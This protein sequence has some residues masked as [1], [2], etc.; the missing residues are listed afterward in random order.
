MGAAK[1]I[2]QNVLP[3]AFNISE[4]V[5]QIFVNNDEVRTTYSF[6]N[7]PSLYS[8]KT[9]AEYFYQIKLYSPNGK[10]FA[11]TKIKVPPFGSTYFVPEQYFG[12]ELPEF[13]MITAEIKP[14]NIFYNSDKHLGKITSHFYAMFMDKG[15]NSVGVI[16][17]QVRIKRKARNQKS[18]VSNQVIETKGLVKIVNYQLNPTGVSLNSNISLVELGGKVIETQ[19]NKLTPYSSSKNV[20][21]NFANCQKV[22]F[23]IDKISAANAKPLIRRS[24]RQMQVWI[25]CW[26]KKW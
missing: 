5:V 25:L 1:K 20:W 21:N 7:F 23:R 10:L 24:S 22:T 13:G 6:T 19:K 26:K 17:P 4:P 11:Q 12:K 9:A 15:M 8:P 3:R 14:K 16:H 2:L 18:W